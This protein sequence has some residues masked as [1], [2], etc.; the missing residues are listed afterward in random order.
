MMAE[1]F[2]AAFVEHGAGLKLV[3]HGEYL[4]GYRFAVVHPTNSDNWGEM[5]VPAYRLSAP[6]PAF[7]AFSQYIKRAKSYILK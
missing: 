7:E 5:H 6:R 2:L 1:A 4:G 3:G